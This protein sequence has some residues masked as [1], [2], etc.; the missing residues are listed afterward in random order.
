MFCNDVCN[1]SAENL[2]QMEII[3]DDD[4]LTLVSSDELTFKSEMRKHLEI[5]KRRFQHIKDTLKKFNCKM[6][7]GKYEVC[8]KGSEV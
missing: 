5:E 1:F 3:L 4:N 7:T 6:S 2:R 8:N